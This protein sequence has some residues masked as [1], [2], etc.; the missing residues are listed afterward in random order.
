MSEV[1]CYLGFI[2]H[3][4]KKFAYGKFI[5]DD[6]RQIDDMKMPLERFNMKPPTGTVV[7]ART[8]VFSHL[9]G[10]TPLGRLELGFRTTTLEETQ[11]LDRIEMAEAMQWIRQAQI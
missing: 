10:S 2:S 1:R 8:Q 6:G 3:C 11:H 7:I 5:R 4:D 9:A